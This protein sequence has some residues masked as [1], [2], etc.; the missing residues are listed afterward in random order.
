MLPATADHPPAWL[1]PPDRALRHFRHHRRVRHWLTGP[2]APHRVIQAIVLLLGGWQTTALAGRAPCSLSPEPVRKRKHAS[3]RQNGAT[4]TQAPDAPP[5]GGTCGGALHPPTGKQSCRQVIVSPSYGIGSLLHDFVPERQPVAV[6][7][8]LQET[9]FELR[10]HFA[11]L[12][13][14]FIER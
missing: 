5:G 2:R 4:P 10:A 1:H 14:C 13:P 7:R 3:A 8:D 6:Q 11:G 12:Q 9:A